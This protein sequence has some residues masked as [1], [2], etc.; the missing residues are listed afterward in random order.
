MYCEEEKPGGYPEAVLV[1][2]GCSARCPVMAHRAC[3]EARWTTR[4]WKCKH[5]HWNNGAREL[6]PQMGC[7][8]KLRRSS[9]TENVRDARL[10]PVD[11]DGKGRTRRART[12]RAVVSSSSE[13]DGGGDGE[14]ADAGEPRTL[15]G[16][17][18][19]DGRACHRACLV[20]QGACRVHVEALRA[21]SRTSHFV[22][23]REAHAVEKAEAEHS[24][25]RR[26]ARE[27]RRAVADERRASRLAQKRDAHASPAPALA[28]AQAS[29]Q[30]SAPA[31]PSA[32]ALTKEARRD[33][34]V[35]CHLDDA[36]ASQALARE[37]ERAHLVRS[38]QDLRGELAQLR[39]ELARARSDGWVAEE[40]ARG[41]E[42]RARGCEERARGCEERA[43]GCEEHAAVFEE[44]AKLAE[45]QLR[46]VADPP[47]P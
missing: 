35:Q 1:V 41:C 45:A 5:A 23:Q 20:G 6:C 33:A 4:V 31:P 40:R 39:E 17:R 42:E 29:A 26:E 36:T 44:R 47:E 38:N 25:A 21:L 8:G 43:R 9:R 27:A 46:I 10:T 28:S 16:A 14:A 19:A 15:C 37:R 3:F 11:V 13:E 32:S 22:T 12:R 30:A 2:A 7:H 34:E 24:V 18:G